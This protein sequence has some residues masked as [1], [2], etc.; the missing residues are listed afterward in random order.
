[1]ERKYSYKEAWI[2]SIKRGER[3]KVEITEECNREPIDLQI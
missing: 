3:A 2:T 1:M